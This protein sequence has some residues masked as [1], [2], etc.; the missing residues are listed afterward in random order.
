[1]D[2]SKEGMGG[3]VIQEGHTIYYKSWKVKEHE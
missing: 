3:V 2:A 1:M